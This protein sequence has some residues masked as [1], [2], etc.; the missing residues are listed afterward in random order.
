MARVLAGREGASESNR[1][2]AGHTS[3]LRSA[4]PE[5]WR[6][7]IGAAPH[8]TIGPALPALSRRSPSPSK[9]DDAARRQHC[10]G[11]Q[12]AYAD[13]GKQCSPFRP[14]RANPAHEQS[15]TDYQETCNHEH[16]PVERDDDN[17]PNSPQCA[18]QSR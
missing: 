1:S 6:S 11:D 3:K 10:S 8:A 13:K 15:T 7:A 16:D 2:C 4:S 18:L 9:Q 12:A 14:I 5:C 17:V